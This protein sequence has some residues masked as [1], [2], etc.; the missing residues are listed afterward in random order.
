MVGMIICCVVNVDKVEL[1]RSL[2][3]DGSVCE[4][5]VHAD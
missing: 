1:A 4:F 3:D 5:R 2:R